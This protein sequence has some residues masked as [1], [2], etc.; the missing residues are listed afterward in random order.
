MPFSRALVM[1]MR[2]KALWFEVRVTKPLTGGVERPS[3]SSVRE[4]WLFGSAVALSLPP[5]KEAVELWVEWHLEASP[6][7]LAEESDLAAVKIDITP[8]EVADLGIPHSGEAHEFDE[9]GTILSLGV[10]LLA[11]DRD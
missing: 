11:A 10:P 4:H 5:F 6:S 3:S 9:V 7:F 8:G 2:L 1:N